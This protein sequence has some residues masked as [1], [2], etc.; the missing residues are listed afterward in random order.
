VGQDVII[1]LDNF[2]Y[3]EFGSLDGTVTSISSVPKE[4]NYLVEVSLTDRT[5]Y[6]SRIDLKQEMQG[7]GDIITQDKRLFEKIFNQF[8]YL[9]KR[10]K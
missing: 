1:K 2:P 5:N 7:T 6:D 8:R 10:N 3:Q 4:N 9:Y